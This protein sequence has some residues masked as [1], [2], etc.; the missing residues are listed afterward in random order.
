L[1]D[2]ERLVVYQVARQYYVLS[3]PWMGRK[4][5]RDLRDQLE[6]AT[7]SILSNIAEGAGKVSKPDK[8]R[9]YEIAKGSTIEAASQLDM[10]NLRGLIS[11][12][13]Y[14]M[15]RAADPRCAH[16]P[17]PVRLPTKVSRSGTP[18][19]PARSVPRPDPLLSGPIPLAIPIPN[20]NPARS[21]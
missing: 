14:Q 12:D 7:T 20:P 15:E 18:P 2:H 11:D 6:R 5:P 4:L 9:F 21:R 17:R 13:E 19:T 1:F 16:A 8:R 10:I 3:L